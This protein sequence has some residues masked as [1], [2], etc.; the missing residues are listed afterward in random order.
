MILLSLLLAWL[1]GLRLK[2]TDDSDR[3]D[4]IDDVDGDLDTE[5]L[6]EGDLDLLYCVLCCSCCCGVCFG[7]CCGGGCCCCWRDGW[8]CVLRCLCDCRLPLLLVEPVVDLRDIVLEKG[9]V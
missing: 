2:F 6:S 1:F 5:R 3:S 7:G 4:E 8:A 9:D